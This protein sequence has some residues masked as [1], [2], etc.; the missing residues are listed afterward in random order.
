MALPLKILSGT[1]MAPNPFTRTGEMRITCHRH[2]FHKVL[3][4][5]ESGVRQKN[6]RGCRHCGRHYTVK[7][8]A[9]P[10]ALATSWIFPDHLQF[11]GWLQSAYQRQESLGI[12]GHDNK[13]T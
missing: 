4:I 8:Q 13:R 2:R 3:D 5:M 11:L 12:I 1:H 7:M 9:K 10:R 6:P